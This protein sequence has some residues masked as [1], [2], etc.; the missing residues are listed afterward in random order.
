MGATGKGVD[1]IVKLLVI[2]A[3]SSSVK[4]TLFQMPDQKVLAGGMVERI[5]LDGT[6]LTYKNWQGCAIDREA[7]VADT[8]QAVGLVT[9]L[10]TNDVNGVLKSIEEITAVGH[11][12]V[13]GGEKMT[14]PVI[15]DSEV[16]TVI[17]ECFELA[18]L[19]NPPNMEGIEACEV[20]L[21]QAT[22]VAVFDTAFHTTIPEE[23][24][25][26][27]LPYRFYREYQIRRYGF[28]GISHKYVAHEAA[29]FCRQPIEAL[30]IITCHLGNGSSMTAVRHGKSVDTSMGFTP[31]EGLIMGTRCG[32][33]DP[34]I[35]PF[36]MGR[37]QIAPQEIDQILNSRSGLLGLAEIGSS[38]MRDILA[39]REAGNRL[40][41]SA[42]R[43]FCYRIKK[44]VG[45][46]TAVMG[47]LDVLVFTAGIGQHCPLVR[48]LVCEGLEDLK[49]FGI[50]L[51]A[52]KNETM[53]DLPAAIHADHS[54]VK[55]L[56]IATNEE[57]EIAQEV[58]R[59][60][61]ARSN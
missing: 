31:L 52:R 26:Y 20:H 38:D 43:S 12:V 57:K 10:L 23:A 33:L 6:R 56:V 32:D 41:D 42:I 61:A 17:R 11:R 2:N 14:S 4:F 13:H 36:L 35:V 3:G 54:A 58:G 5:G 30:K 34:A 59:V 60:L 7:A 16:K 53:A 28:H 27:G 46:Y 47:G 18:P 22:Q 40:A 29:R 48:W 9:A 45:A 24:Y 15:I 55:V 49:G 1:W 39:A 51:D 8:A 21:P 37:K 44:Y 25:L 50:A 19:H